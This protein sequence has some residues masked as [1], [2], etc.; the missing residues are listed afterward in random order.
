MKRLSI[1]LLTICL[2]IISATADTW[3]DPETNFT[4]TY[5]L[6]DGDPSEVII[7]L[8]TWVT[9]DIVIPSTIDGHTVTGIGS[10]AFMG[11][12]NLTSVSIPNTVTAIGDGAFYDCTNM[13]SAVIPNAVTSIGNSA[14]SYT[15][16]TTVNIPDAVTSI[17]NT[18][19]QACT[20][21]TSV[22][23]GSSVTTIGDG[24]FYACTN[25]TA[26]T[27]PNSVT[28]IGNAAFAYCPNVTSIKVDAGNTTYDSRD[29]C[30]AIIKTATNEMIAGCKNTVIP[31]TVTDIA[32]RVFHGCTGLTSIDI[33]NSVTTIG[34]Y[35]FQYCS[36][37]VSAT[38]G[39]T[40][41]DIKN[42]T[43]EGCTS[44]V[45]VTIGNSVTTIENYAF[46]DCRSLTAVVI[47]NSVTTIRMQAFQN[48]TSMT[49]ITM[50]NSV[51]D[52]AFQAFE[53]CTAL[54]K[55]IVKDLA[56]WCKVELSYYTNNPLY[57]AHHLYSDE[58]TEI[59]SLN[60]P[61]SVT[62]INSMA[63]EG[64]SYLTSVN[65]G[66]SVETIGFDAF[67]DC[68]AL[69]TVTIGNSVTSI[70]SGAFSNCTNLRELYNYASEW[71]ETSETAF[72]GASIGSATLYVQPP[73]L[74][75]Y[76]TT[77]PWS[78]FGTILTLAE[79]PKCATPVI[80]YANGKATFSCPTEGAT[81]Y[82][83]VATDFVE[84]TSGTRAEVDF[85][86]IFRVRAQAVKQNYLYSD[87]A[88][89]DIPLSNS[90]GKMGDLNNDGNINV[91]DITILVNLILGR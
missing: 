90:G 85:N 36:G 66:N 15:A 55:V 14:F 6:T 67:G 20:S 48:C 16:L 23:I 30:N 47:P 86:P 81:I 7:G 19:F 62:T 22:T 63:F 41:T 69:T 79:M 49:T 28:T 84:E 73:F 32:A 50:G 2:G 12:K 71:P 3:T 57:Y 56:A 18:A 9:G 29:N 45:S 40:V 11:C 24:A 59:I 65:I 35:A 39:N 87:V 68:T 89:K 46:R 82:Y 17:G 54:Q 21:L 25:L 43:F 76:Q 58:N 31:N 53:N 70:E 74:D 4:W 51:R 42:G 64:C 13:T 34:Q 1:F 27:I 77:V 10:Q 5:S 37:L 8:N 88:V 38:I 80:N 44:L 60:I 33:P 61:S 72:K 78:G 52:I 26:I 83:T 75:Q 91:N